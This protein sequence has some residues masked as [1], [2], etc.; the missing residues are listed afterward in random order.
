MLN[1]LMQIITAIS[2]TNSRSTPSPLSRWFSFRPRTPPPR[3]PA[4]IR[5]STGQ[6]KSG[7]EPVA[8]VVSRLHSWLKKMIYR[9]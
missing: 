6:R 9:G 7:T 8:R 4:T 1:R 3:P 2:T 5:A